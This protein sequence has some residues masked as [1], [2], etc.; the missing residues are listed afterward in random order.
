MVES[1]VSRY[2]NHFNPSRQPNKDNAL[3][4]MLIS[5]NE[6]I[7]YRADIIL[8]EA[9]NK[10]WKD[11][12]KNGKWHFIWQSEDIRSYASGFSKV[13]S[14]LYEQKSNL[15][16]MWSILYLRCSRLQA[17]LRCI[18]YFVRYKQFFRGWIVTSF[19]CACIWYFIM[20]FSTYL[21][22]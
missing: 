8:E 22:C 14:K 10:Y 16:F 12:T 20:L 6:P 17:L 4:E 15:P 18:C 7:L 21:G 2:E 5:E 19:T 9:M 11:K 1:L 13:L 3:N